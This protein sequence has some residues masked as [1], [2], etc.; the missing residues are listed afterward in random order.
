[1]M[2]QRNFISCFTNKSGREKVL[3]NPAVDSEN[4]ESFL[5][6]KIQNL[7]DKVKDLKPSVLESPFP[8]YKRYKYNPKRRIK[9][10]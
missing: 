7:T 2:D 9:L 6:D 3:R 1:M 8:G 10:S 5:E 4:P